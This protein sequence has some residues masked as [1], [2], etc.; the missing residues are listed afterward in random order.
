MRAIAVLRA[1]PSSRLP[2]HAEQGSRNPG[3][4]RPGISVLSA[5]A[6]PTSHRH[7]STALPY[8]AATGISRLLLEHSTCAAASSCSRSRC[9]RTTRTLTAAQ[10]L[11]TGY[12]PDT[13]TPLTVYIDGNHA[14]DGKLADATKLSSTARNAMT[15]LPYRLMLPPLARRVAYTALGVDDAAFVAAASCEKQSLRSF[16]KPTRGVRKT[17]GP[18]RTADVRV[19]DN[20]HSPL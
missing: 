18:R 3:P 8:S 15:A 1:V 4:I 2:V 11:T 12:T 13:A 6:G 10:A 7:A 5:D 14:D 19:Q 20:A 9:C 17:P 16:L